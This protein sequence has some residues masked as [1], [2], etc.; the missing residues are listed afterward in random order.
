MRRLHLL[1]LGASLLWLAVLAARLSPPP[2]AEATG[3]LAPAFPFHEYWRLGFTSEG[4][5]AYTAAIGR[6]V[7]G[8]AAFRSSRAGGDI[9]F[10][11]PPSAETLEVRAIQAN[12][13][14]RSGAYSGTASL[15]FEVRA[16]SGVLEHVVSA[17]P[18]DLEAAPAG[19][20]AGV[21]RSASPADLLI[22]PGQV[23]V[24]RATFSEGAR[25]DLDVRAIF[26]IEVGVPEPP[27]T[28]TPTATPVTP[29]P[30]GL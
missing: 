18:L 28:P 21:A 17:A 15:A 6:D 30:I 29:E 9:Y 3:W 24:A 19:E 7:A 22:A 2:A 8:V 27:A 10:I 13:L 23:L 12:V 5:A 20:W 25:D 1:L 14:A 16:L 11:F 4:G 26:E